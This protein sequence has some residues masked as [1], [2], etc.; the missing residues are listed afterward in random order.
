MRRLRSTAKVYAPA[1]GADR[2][3]LCPLLSG[4]RANGAHLSEPPAPR[5]SQRKRQLRPAG[6]KRL[7][8]RPARES[9]LRESTY[10]AGVCE[11][12]PLRRA[13][14]GHATPHLLAIQLQNI[15]DFPLAL[16]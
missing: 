13:R 2:S 11:S 3:F 6:L 14:S 15:V 7:W 10:A 4:L 1:N 16:P 8:Q 5:A 9:A 12:A